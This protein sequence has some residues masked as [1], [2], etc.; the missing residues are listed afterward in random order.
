M[1]I[2]IK[3]KST[4]PF[5][6]FVFTDKF[7]FK[8]LT[9]TD[10]QRFVF[11][12]RVAL[13]L[14]QFLIASVQKELEND[15][16][17]HE[18]TIKR[19]NKTIENILKNVQEPKCIDVEEDEEAEEEFE[20]QISEIEDRLDSCTTT[21]ELHELDVKSTNEIQDK[22]ENVLKVLEDVKNVV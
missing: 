12:P 10:Q 15:K 1:T 8:V 20:E 21:V 3:H 11:N 22:L 5:F 14:A 6:A 9:R 4:Y 2:A 19:V 16:R 18:L 17:I 13:E 7:E